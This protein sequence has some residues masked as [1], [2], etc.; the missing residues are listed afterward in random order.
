MV[1]VIGGLLL[2]IAFA[3]LFS[4]MLGIFG[5]V[6]ITGSLIAAFII[7]AVV[8]IFGLVKGFFLYKLMEALGTKSD[9]YAGVSVFAYTLVPISFGFLLAA[10][11][12]MV[13]DFGVVLAFLFGTPFILMGVA[14]MYYAIK[15]FFKTDMVISLIA[16]SA[17]MLG[18]LIMVYLILFYV[19][20]QSAGALASA[21]MM[22]RSF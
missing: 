19:I 18:C 10:V 15:N 22:P 4:N 13:P 5:S 1:L 6:G 7:F 8:V 21:M 12:M 9:Y 16:V 2:A 14:T 20:F 11:L 3:L 17:F